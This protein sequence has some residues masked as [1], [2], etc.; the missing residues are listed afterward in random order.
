MAT[1]NQWLRTNIKDRIINPQTKLVV[2]M[3]IVEYAIVPFEE[4]S[5]NVVRK[6]VEKHDNI[7]IP[8]SGGM[9]SEYV[10]NC[11]LGNKFTPIIV[12]TQANKEESSFAF[13][14]CAKANITPVV[15]EKTEK[16]MLQIYYDEIYKKLKGIGTGSI[17]TYIA[18][19]YADDHNGVA[20]I[21]EHGYDGFNEWDFYNDVLI[22]EENS[23]YFFMYD[24]EIFYA[25][26]KE[27]TQY[28]HHQEFKHRI[29]D[30]PIREKMSYKYTDK[31]NNVI[32]QLITRG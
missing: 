7:F 32:R 22:H 12:D 15:I 14:R 17:A 3:D 21:G 8:L 11:F 27:F 25:M 4:A 24:P 26:K 31:F 16:E 13:R 28:D 5:K 23:I 1:E 9:D 20:V 6:I 19:K 2:E 29:Y 10:F 18:G 30:I